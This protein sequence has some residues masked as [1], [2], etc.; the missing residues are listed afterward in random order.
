M[1]S[2]TEL[3]NH[4][5]GQLCTGV[6]GKRYHGFH[7]GVGR[8]IESPALP[9]KHR[10]KESSK[11]CIPLPPGT[12]TCDTRLW[13]AKYKKKGAFMRAA[14]AA[15]PRAKL[16]RRHRHPLYIGLDTGMRKTVPRTT[17]GLV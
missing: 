12:R 2:L 5:C 16:A 7:C 15:G 11:E 6:T 4:P 17:L 3:V 13:D 1:H 14:H 9:D 8:I 10:R